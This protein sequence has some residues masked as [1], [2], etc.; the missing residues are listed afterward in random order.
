MHRASGCITPPCS[1]WDWG[2]QRFRDVSC[3]TAADHGS[4]IDLSAYSLGFL[5][6]GL[7]R[8]AHVWIDY[9]QRRIAFVPVGSAEAVSPA[10]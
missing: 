3:L 9:P 10:A 2:G 8:R 4:G 5:G 1:G 6:G 7:L